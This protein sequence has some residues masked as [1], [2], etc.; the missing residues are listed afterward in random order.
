[1][2]QTNQNQDKI[3]LKNWLQLPRTEEQQ[4]SEYQSLFYGLHHSCHVLKDHYSAY[5][6][7]FDP[8]YASSLGNV[9]DQVYVDLM[10]A[11]KVSFTRTQSLPSQY[12]NEAQQKNVAFLVTFAV[13]LYLGYGLQ[14]GLLNP[15][16]LE[17]NFEQCKQFLPGEDIPYYEGVILNHQYTYY[18]DYVRTRQLD[19]DAN[20]L[21]GGGKG[22]SKAYVKKTNKQFVIEPVSY[23][24]LAQDVN[25]S[26]AGF[27]QSLILNLIFFAISMIMV[28]IVL[29][30]YW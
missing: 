4:R 10:D 26:K 22:N 11:Q 13:G 30:L 16:F 12:L 24:N 27:S 18:D 8:Y 6:P 17:N 25:I 29:L 3:S 1:M 15:S 9:L 2:A 23:E 14:N 28:G 21:D 7:Y 20:D 5:F 19:G